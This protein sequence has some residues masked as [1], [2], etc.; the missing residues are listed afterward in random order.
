MLNYLSRR[1]EQEQQ[2][3][4]EFIAHEIHD[5]ACQYTTAARMMFDAFRREQ[6]STLPGDW[7]SFEMGLE[8][9]NHAQEELRR[10]V[11]GLRPIQLAASDLPKAIECL[12]EQ[13]HAAG[14][15]DIELC[16]DIQPDR[17]PPRLELAAF[18]IVQESLSNAC[19]HSQSKGI[20][21]GLTQDDDS[22]CI[23]VQDWGVGFKPDQTASGHYGLEGIRRRVKLLHGIVTID[24]DPSEGGTLITVELPLKE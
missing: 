5:G 20:L 6:T 9:L 23:Q 3:Q 10:L 21:V 17:I 18:R 24:S 12:I 16:C 1:R 14:G 11:H 4:Q 22:L 15:P 7:S 19:R 2:H 8:F 13:L